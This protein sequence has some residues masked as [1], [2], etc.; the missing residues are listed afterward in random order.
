[1]VA[2]GG[3]AAGFSRMEVHVTLKNKSTK[4]DD[5]LLS[6]LLSAL[7]PRMSNTQT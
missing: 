4:Y 7:L 5:A 2:I 1:M 6:A 3:L